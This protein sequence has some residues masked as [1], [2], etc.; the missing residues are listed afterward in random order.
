MQCPN[1]YRSIH[2]KI[3][4]LVCFNQL[5]KYLLLV[6]NNISD[7]QIKYWRGIKPKGKPVCIKMNGKT[8]IYMVFLTL[9]DRLS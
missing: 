5:P 2:I 1:F 3:I 8:E 9:N 4:K 6:E 7:P